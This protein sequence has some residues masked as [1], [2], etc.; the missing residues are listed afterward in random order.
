MFVCVQQYIHVCIILYSC[1]YKSVSHMFLYTH[2]GLY[3]LYICECLVVCVCVYILYICESSSVCVSVCVC[4][5]DHSSLH[6]YRLTHL[7][8]H[9]FCPVN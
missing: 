5:S 1:V 4:V 9:S 2:M 3:H 8:I 6:G 7:L